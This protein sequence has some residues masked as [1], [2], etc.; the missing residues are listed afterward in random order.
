[1]YVLNFRYN[2]SQQYHR[3]IKNMGYIQ[4]LPSSLTNNMDFGLILLFN[5][6]QFLY[7]ESKCL[8]YQVKTHSTWHVEISQ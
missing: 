2:F 4:I 5:K 7:N 6:A 8:K 1:M 3:V